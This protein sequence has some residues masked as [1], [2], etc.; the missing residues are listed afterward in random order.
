MENLTLAGLINLI[1]T[2]SERIEEEMKETEE[3]VKNLTNKQLYC[4]K[5]IRRLENPNLSELAEA[6]KITKPSASVMIDKLEINGYV[7]KVRLDADR[8]NSHIHLTNL[9]EEADAWH[10]HV[11]RKIAS[12]L[13]Q[14]L[15]Q[16][17]ENHLVRL[18]NQAVLSLK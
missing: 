12:L 6:L 9:G 17:E 1:L 18:L 13:S 8:R 16:D 11:H 2:K 14:N 5:I 3:K 10:S 7:Q 15:D 4:I